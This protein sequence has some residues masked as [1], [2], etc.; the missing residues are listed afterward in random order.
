MFVTV[1]CIKTHD[2]LC[3]VLLLQRGSDYVSSEQL[4]VTLM[5]YH[6]ICRRD[7]I[8]DRE[9]AMRQLNA[10]DDDPSVTITDLC[11]GGVYVF[12]VAAVNQFGVSGELDEG[13]RAEIL[14]DRCPTDPRK[15]PGGKWVQDECK[16]LFKVYNVF[17]EP[18]NTNTQSITLLCWHRYCH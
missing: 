8:F 7:N 10:T 12:S 4:V 15:Q 14:E 2:S 5:L 18:Q 13:V 9:T 11:P 17:K 1:T 3:K 16:E 6:S